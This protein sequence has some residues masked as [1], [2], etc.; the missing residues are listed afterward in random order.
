MFDLEFVQKTTCIG[1]CGIFGGTLLVDFIVVKNIFT[2]NA[3]FFVLHV[4]FNTW[5]TSVVYNDAVDALMNPVNATQP[6]WPY[7]TIVT[8][9][10]IAGFHLY[11]LMFFVGLS[12]EDL[13]HHCVSCIIVP[14]M[15]ILCPYGRIVA[16]VNLGM[17]GVPGGIDYFLLVMVKYKLIDKLTEKYINRWLNLVIRWPLMLLSIYLIFVAFVNSKF[18]EH[19]LTVRAFVVLGGFLHSAN[20]IYYCD[21][22]VGN[23]HI[24]AVRKFAEKNKVK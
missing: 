18:I 3:R 21:K 16:V 23:Y 15:G 22:V 5:V 24:N 13:V 11:H 9:A 2:K 19:S 12:T 20:A 7:S 4:I 14:V 17:C 1:F 6:F 8:T 10:G